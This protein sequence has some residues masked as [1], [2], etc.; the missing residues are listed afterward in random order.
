MKI[1]TE[2]HYCGSGN[3]NEKSFL[4]QDKKLLIHG[5]CGG[6]MKTWTETWTLTKLEKYSIRKGEKILAASG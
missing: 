6:C 5:E 4:H 2:C 3:V 1:I